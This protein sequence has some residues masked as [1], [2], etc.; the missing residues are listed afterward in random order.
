MN[1]EKMLA[2]IGAAVRRGATH[3]PGEPPER[4]S[5]T[6]PAPAEN[7]VGLF[8]AALG[9]SRVGFT[10]AGCA[11]DLGES[12]ESL[13]ASEAGASVA[14]SDAVLK[15]LPGFDERLARRGVRVVGP[16]YGARA[17]RG[18]GNGDGTSEETN[19]G[20][21][22]L[23]EAHRRALFGCDAGVTTADFAIAD[24]GTLVLVSGGERH[25]LISLLPTVHVCL[26][27]TNRIL[28]DMGRLL[29]RVRGE[30]GKGG[31]LPQAMTF[32]SGPSRTADIEQTLTTGVH[33]PHKLHVLLYE[34]AAV[35]ACEPA[36]E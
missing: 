35:R 13:L 4:S 12:L 9:A 30:A 1:K 27:E 11:A 32:I 24:T 25:R 34:P 10:R 15:L 2:R 36:R 29:E 26:L 21:A 14:L 16:P 6:A 3:A 23:A 17:A 18:A 7:V 19:V 20:D 22:R 28:P 31:P 8:C 5:V 33:G